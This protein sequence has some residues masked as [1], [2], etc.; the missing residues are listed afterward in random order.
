MPTRLTRAFSGRLARGLENRFMKQLENVED[1]L[2]A[3]PVQNALTASIRADAAK[4]GDTE[5]MSLW[6]G[7]EVRRARA[8]ESDFQ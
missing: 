8:M 4:T 7:A 2:P 6:A 5:L 3:Y 1:Q